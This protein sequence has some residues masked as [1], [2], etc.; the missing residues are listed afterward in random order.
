VIPNHDGEDS[1]NWEA[2]YYPL[3]N[4]R[5]AFLMVVA[6][7]R[8]QEPTGAERCEEDLLA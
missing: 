4:A 3:G 2:F 5:R 1:E 7:L 6:L 8:G